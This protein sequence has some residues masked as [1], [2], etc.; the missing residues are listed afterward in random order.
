MKNLPNCLRGRIL[1]SVCL[2]KSYALRVV[3][4]NEPGNHYQICMFQQ[5]L[6]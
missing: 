5:I 4:K 6:L 2:G 1:E 3:A